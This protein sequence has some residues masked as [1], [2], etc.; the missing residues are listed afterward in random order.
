MEIVQCRLGN[1][2]FPSKDNYPNNYLVKIL[3]FTAFL[4]ANRARQAS[5]LTDSSRTPAPDQLAGQK[6]GFQADFKCDVSVASEGLHG[7]LLGCYTWL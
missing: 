2:G 7:V 4:I 1:R 5:K 3:H 6:V